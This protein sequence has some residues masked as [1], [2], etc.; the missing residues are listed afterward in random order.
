MLA[1]WTIFL[2]I[3]FLFILTGTP[4]RLE[5]KHSTST[6]YRLTEI[7]GSAYGFTYFSVVCLCACVCRCSLCTV[8]ADLC[9]GKRLSVRCF[10]LE[11]GPLRICLDWLARAQQSC[12]PAQR[13]SGTCCCGNQTQ[14]HRLEQQTSDQLSYLV[15]PHCQLLSLK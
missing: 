13:W 7:N 1:I 15:D 11:T 6:S 2:K 4:T 14:V 5:F 8:C 10:T 3:K 12:A 9:G